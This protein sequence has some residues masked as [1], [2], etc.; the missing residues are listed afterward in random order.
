MRMIRTA[1][2]SIALLMIPLAALAEMRLVMVEQPGCI[3]C[4]AW[5]DEISAIYPL[6]D[7]GK[8][9][10]LTRVQLRGPL[11]DGMQ[12]ARPAAFTPTFVLLEDG[13]EVG[14]IEGYPG[15]DFFWALLGE[16]IGARQT[17]QNDN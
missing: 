17:G 3:Y 2:L 10:P 6:T 7:E 8:A 5:N 4:R 9:A 11:P 1:L 13:T 12:F 14:R 15:E 16:M